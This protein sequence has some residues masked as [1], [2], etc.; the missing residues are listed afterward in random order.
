MSH[1]I[2]EKWCH[3]PSPARYC[4]YVLLLTLTELVEIRKT[5]YCCQ[6]CPVLFCSQKDVQCL[7]HC[8]LVG[9]QGWWSVCMC[10]RGRKLLSIYGGLIV[11][12]S[13]YFHKDW[14]NPNVAFLRLL[15][16]CFFKCLFVEEGWVIKIFLYPCHN[17]QRF[18]QKPVSEAKVHMLNV[19]TD[20]M[21]LLSK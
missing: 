19:N 12:V 4:V 15:R 16:T 13:F 10:E 6:L 8:G 21:K 14:W 18:S 20:N 17:R 9:N 3:L 2:V 11:C 5:A 7:A 1:F